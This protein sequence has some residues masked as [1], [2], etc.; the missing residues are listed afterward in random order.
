[1]DVSNITSLTSISLNGCVG[2]NGS[3]LDL[4]TSPYITSIDLRGT[5]AGITLVN[6][7]VSSLQL[8]SPLSVYIDRPKRLTPSGVTIQSSSNL[9]NI[10]L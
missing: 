7:A 3:V 6:S 5:S 1:M 2:L 9:D 10:Y 4:T 8:G